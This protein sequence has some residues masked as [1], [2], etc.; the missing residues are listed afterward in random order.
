MTREAPVAGHAGVC[1]VGR[2]LSRLAVV[3][4]VA[5]VAAG[6]GGEN[7]PPRPDLALVSSRDGDYAIYVL[8][9]DGSRQTRLTEEGGNPETRTG[10]DFQ[11]DPAWSRDGRRIAF[12][13]RR[14]GSLDVYVMNADGSDTRR[15]TST[16]DEDRHPSFAPD[17]RQIAFQ[18]GLGEL[19]VA[20]LDGERARRV[21][22]DLAEES[23]PAWSP[24]GQWI[25]YVRR[26]PGTSIR[27]IWLVRPDGSG[28]RQLT[29]RRS[30]IY[31]PAWSPDGTRI[32]FASES[33]GR[34]LEIFEIRVDGTRLRKV[35]D[36][37]EDTVEP[38]FAPD[39]TRIA[40]ARGGAIVIVDADGEEQ[41]LTSSSSNDSSPV[42]NPVPGPDE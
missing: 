9:A 17:G 16:R 30:T 4:L 24:D 21:T 2:A 29:K 36:S 41:V 10:V 22:D 23:E 12:V 26:A 3:V 14:S 13:S 6:C 7:G 42:W 39:G 8:D 19:F 37:M 5:L 38:A 20:G 31:E 1:G 15:L 25:A 35:T 18:R 28:R 11:L 32:A 33:P 40:F 34:I 27:E